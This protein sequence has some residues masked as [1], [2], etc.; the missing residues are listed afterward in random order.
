MFS[1]SELFRDIPCPNGVGNC[2]LINCIFSHK[3]Q[4]T[5][6]T[7]GS[8]QAACDI[9]DATGD[10]KRRKLDNGS[11]GVTNISVPPMRVV[12]TGVKPTSKPAT[13]SSTP[14]DSSRINE[15]GIQEETKNGLSR[16]LSTAT[17]PISPP[18]IGLQGRKPAVN[19][20]ATAAKS[21]KPAETLN[22]R[23]VPRDPAPHMTRYQLLKHLHDAMVKLNDEARCSNDKDISSLHQDSQ[24]LISAAL[25]EEERF[26]TG[27][28]TVYTNL[29]KSR[30]AAYRKM[31]L[32]EWANQQRTIEAAKTKSQELKATS[33]SQQ[34]QQESDRHKP[35]NLETDLSIVQQIAMLNRYILKPQDLRNA[36]YVTVPP[37]EAAMEEAWKT[38]EA[39]GFYEKCERCDTRFQVYPEGRDEDGAV[40]TNGKCQHHWGKLRNP[41]RG[42]GSKGPVYNC[43]DAAQGTPGCT[44][45]DSHV[46]K[47]NGA[48]RLASILPFIDTPVN[49]KAKED[50]AVAFDCEMC[51]TCYGL[52]LVRLSATA[53]PHGEP[54]IDVLVRPIGTVLDLNTQFSGVSVEQFFGAEEYDPSKDGPITPVPRDMQSSPTESQ[55]ALRIVSSPSAARSLLL[56]YIS[57]DTVLIGHSLDNDMNV[58]RLI[59]PKIVDTSLL[60]PHPGGLPYR[61]GLKALVKRFLQRN[62]QTGGAEGHDSLE[63]ARGT[64]DLVRWKIAKEWTTL[65]DKGWRA[66]SGGQLH[67]FIGPEDA[68]GEKSGELPPY[69]Q[70]QGTLAKPKKRRHGDSGF[71]VG[72]D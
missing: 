22:P 45:G 31:K 14:K 5:P 72:T 15:H 23:T 29:V 43:C 63:D 40:T 11:K 49:E 13:L 32:I 2:T 54:L 12:F 60:F 68:K 20:A 61:Y 57:T 26:A 65:K 53:W 1:S 52:E 36:G 33:R 56:S 8:E 71:Q 6:T 50:F 69:L 42:G 35:I 7:P 3:L 4:N 34:F 21:I 62:I 51:W 38:V 44:T 64:G 18:P 70:P 46:F 39:S 10:Q 37:T 16:E 55:Q 17:R 9:V 27:K 58:M 19:K 41:E 59:H 48:N 25:D 66:D 30:I 28:A 24:Q 47:I 67:G